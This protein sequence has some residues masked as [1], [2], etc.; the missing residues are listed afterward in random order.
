MTLPDVHPKYLKELQLVFDEKCRYHNVPSRKLHLQHNLSIH[1]RRVGLR[2]EQLAAL[3]EAIKRVPCVRYLDVRENCITGKG[4]ALL[5][6]ALQHQLSVA[7]AFPNNIGTVCPFSSEHVHFATPADVCAMSSAGLRCFRPIVFLDK[8]ALED[9]LLDGNVVPVKVLNSMTSCITQ[10]LGANARLR[11]LRAVAAA[12]ES[13]QRA[14]DHAAFPR[15]FHALGIEAGEE[16]QRAVL[17][18]CAADDEV[19]G[20]A[21]PSEAQ[22]LI[23]LLHR[24]M[25]L[26]AQNRGALSQRRG[27]HPLRWL[28]EE[29]DP[30]QSQQLAAFWSCFSQHWQ[31]ESALRCKTERSA[32]P[33]G[34]AAERVEGD[35]AGGEA[36]YPALEDATVSM[37]W[38]SKQHRWARGVLDVS[39]VLL[40][41]PCAGALAASLSQHPIV[42]TLVLSAAQ[43]HDARILRSFVAALQRQCGLVAAAAALDPSAA[44]TPVYFLCSL[45]T[46]STAIDGGSVDAELE[47]SIGEACGMLRAANRRLLLQRK[48]A[49]AFW[50]QD[51]ADLRRRAGF[52]AFLS[53]KAPELVGLVDAHGIPGHVA[54]SAH[55][56]LPAEATERLSGAAKAAFAREVMATWEAAKAASQAAFRSAREGSHAPFPAVARTPSR[57]RALLTRQRSTVHPLSSLPRGVLCTSVSM[58]S[59]AQAKR[60]AVRDDPVR[61]H[62]VRPAGSPRFRAMPLARM[63][64][65]R[66]SDHRSSRHRVAYVPFSAAA[67]LR[68]YHLGTLD[69]T[70]LQLQPEQVRAVLSVVERYPMV[71]GIH[72]DGNQLDR[73]AVEALLNVMVAHCGIVE[74]WGDDAT[75]LPLGSG[76]MLEGQ[77]VHFLCR[78]SLSVPPTDP[79]E[80]GELLLDMLA[81]L[82]ARAEKLRHA[83]CVLQARRMF[84]DADRDGAGTVDAAKLKHFLRHGGRSATN[85]EVK[86]MVAD[87][88]LDF[89]NKIDA[90]ELIAAVVQQGAQGD[91][92]RAEEGGEEGGAAARVVRIGFEP[93]DAGL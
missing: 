32:V 61:A 91:A 79:E 47:H 23:D 53:P 45:P 34:S 92:G 64:G 42:H 22:A 17:A 55:P 38:D 50:L 89:D 11:V 39:D 14:L 49:H 52:F 80:V 76:L 84:N 78:V 27:K 65:H 15:V 1:L 5:H 74:H 90:A 57:L 48:L 60:P 86:R 33:L 71:Q 67:L 8:I 24:G 81:E 6:E 31:A 26:A 12:T 28:E 35:G 40:S 75:K 41:A 7:H 56:R 83:N 72:L 4:S 51:A 3:A 69:L 73:R 88:D 82:R 70:G 58:D 13:G 2:D 36:A 93:Q 19:T 68:R 20:S 63:L 25:L 59:G 87:M 37:I 85:R 66:R 16:T 77:P 54:L 29:E 18:E 46:S 44:S 30:V 21:H 62:S 9:D 43:R 10:L